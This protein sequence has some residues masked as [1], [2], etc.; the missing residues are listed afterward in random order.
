[1]SSI[2]PPSSDQ[3]YYFILKSLDSL[4]KSV[5]ELQASFTAMQSVLVS[6]SELKDLR[7]HY[8][9]ELKSVRDRCDAQDKEKGSEINALKVKSAV[10]T[11]IVA[12][13]I[14]WAVRKLGG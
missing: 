2:P 5:D 9:R 3:A 6:R 1:M 13:V 12:A 8:D 11:V 7:D 10:V 14:S 4:S